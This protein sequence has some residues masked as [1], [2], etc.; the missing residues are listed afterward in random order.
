LTR[1]ELRHAKFS[2][3]FISKVEELTEWTFSALPKNFPYIL[4]SSR[5]QMRDTEFLGQL[6]LLIEEGAKS[7]SQDDLDAAFSSR[8]PQWEKMDEVATSYRIAIQK[9]D[10]IVRCDSTGDLA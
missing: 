10:E 9:I 4:P 7:Y 5:K 2:G 3:T 8:D 1:Q 6:L